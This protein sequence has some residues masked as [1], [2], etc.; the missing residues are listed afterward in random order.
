MSLKPV[1][2]SS[3]RSLRFLKLF[4]PLAILVS[5]VWLAFGD[6]K[7]NARAEKIG[8]IEPVQKNIEGWTVHVDPTLLEGGENAE[9]GE[10]AIKMLANH[11]QRICIL[12]PEKQLDKMKTM[13]IWLENKHPELTGMQY[14]P[15]AGWLTGRGYDPRLAKKVHITNASALFSR[16]QMLKHPAVIL[17]ELAHA[18]H[19]QVLSFDDRKIIEAYDTAM[20]KGILEKV[21]LFTGRTVRHYA[22]TNH[23]E[24]FAEATEAY[25]YCNDFYP[26][27]AAELKD[28]DPKAFAV[29]KEVWGPA[30]VR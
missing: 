7:E 11:L 18:Y 21:K 27:V 17:H 16:E 28:F 24:Y 19:D 30:A 29:M 12:L 14:H 2:P 26:F 22:A 23:K 13:E 3:S 4:A 15:G 9:T 10:K 1:L 5:S 8:W 6:K 20:E 25:L